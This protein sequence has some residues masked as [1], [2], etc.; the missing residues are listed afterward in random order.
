MYLKT[1]TTVRFSQIYIKMDD[2]IS[3]IKEKIEVYEKTMAA[4]SAIY[5]KTT[6]QTRDPKDDFSWVSHSANVKK[7]FHL[8]H[9]IKLFSILYQ[10]TLDVT[11][12][13]I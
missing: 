6:L 5:T 8:T 1:I 9:W 3:S 11:E 7:I 4:S 13:K 2:I 12:I 10:S